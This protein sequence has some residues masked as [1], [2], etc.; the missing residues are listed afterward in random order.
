MNF[1]NLTILPQELH[2]TVAKIVGE[3]ATPADA[4]G[5]IAKTIKVGD[6]S[7]EFGS[8]Y[9]D[10]QIDKLLNDYQSELYD[11]RKVRW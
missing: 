1:C 5:E 10:N 8:R 6:T 7:V 9:V 2:Y 3:L 11:F 4:K